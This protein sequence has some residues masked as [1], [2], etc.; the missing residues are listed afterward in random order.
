MTRWIGL[1]YRHMNETTLHVYTECPE[2]KIIAIAKRDSVPMYDPDQMKG[3][4]W[5]AWCQAQNRIDNP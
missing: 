5:C 4:E 1:G 2:G 3:L